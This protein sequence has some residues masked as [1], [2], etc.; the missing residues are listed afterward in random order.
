MMECVGYIL[1]QVKDGI[2]KYSLPVCMSA[3]YDRFL[4]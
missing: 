2:F 3:V 4:S 1:S